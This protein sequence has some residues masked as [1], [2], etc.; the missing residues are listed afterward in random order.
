MTN[1]SIQNNP[2]APSADAPQDANRKINQ[3]DNVCMPFSTIQQ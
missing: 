3:S 1:A 2:E